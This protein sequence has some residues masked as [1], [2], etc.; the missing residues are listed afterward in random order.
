M[1]KARAKDNGFC[2]LKE[3]FYH[4]SGLPAAKV[5]KKKTIDRAFTKGD[6]VS[7]RKRGRDKGEKDDTKSATGACPI[8]L[9]VHIHGTTVILAVVKESASIGT[10]NERGVRKKSKW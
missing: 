3:G 8:D 4:S 9:E 1:E 10:Q 7:P 6:K 5:M 2:I